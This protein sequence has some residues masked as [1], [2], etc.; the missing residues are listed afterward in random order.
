MSSMMPAI[1]RREAAMNPDFLSLLVIGATT[2]F[3]LDAACCL[4]LRSNAKRLNRR[5][6]HVRT[7]DQ[8]GNRHMLAP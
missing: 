3:A 7:A 5:A 4:W 1:A 8:R 6:V 2:L